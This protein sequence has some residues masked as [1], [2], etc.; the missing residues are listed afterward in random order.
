MNEEIREEI[1]ETALKRKCENP[2]FYMIS[3]SEFNKLLEYC[4]VENYDN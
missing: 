4:G 2:D 3:K 1:R